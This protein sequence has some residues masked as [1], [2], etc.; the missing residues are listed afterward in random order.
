MIQFAVIVLL[1]ALAAGFAA[2]A[3]VMRMHSIRARTIGALLVTAALPL[4]AVAAA[5]AAGRAD[6]RRGEAGRGRR[7]RAE[8]L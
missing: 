2:T 5:V 6:G 1:I 8:A 3:L 4:I 7:E